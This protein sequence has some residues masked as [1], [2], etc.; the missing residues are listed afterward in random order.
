M[1]S[2]ELIVKLKPLL[3][4]DLIDILIYYEKKLKNMRNFTGDKDLFVAEDQP[5]LPLTNITHQNNLKCN[6]KYDLPE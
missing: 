5:M 1:F 6:R 4:E 2:E 3:S